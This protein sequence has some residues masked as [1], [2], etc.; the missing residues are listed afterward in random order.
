MILLHIYG[1]NIYYLKRY[2]RISFK[3]FNGER[4]LLYSSENLMV[5]L[6]ESSYY[7]NTM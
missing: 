4:M 5:G 6:A 3:I 1:K 2:F 7:S